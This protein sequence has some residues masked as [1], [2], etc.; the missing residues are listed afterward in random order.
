MVIVERLADMKLYI[1]TFY[2]L[3][4]LYGKQWCSGTARFTWTMRE[5]QESLGGY[6]SNTDAWS[7][8]T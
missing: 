8:F 5:L 3:K 7:A 4:Q 6:I 2:N 1:Q